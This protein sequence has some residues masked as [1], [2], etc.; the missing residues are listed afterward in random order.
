MLSLSLA[1]KTK[2]KIEYLW[3]MVDAPLS[4]HYLQFEFIL[5]SVVVLEVVELYLLLLSHRLV[6][7]RLGIFYDSELFIVR[8]I[9]QAPWRHLLHQQR[10]RRLV[11]DE[12][13]KIYCKKKKKI[14]TGD[15]VRG[16]HLFLLS[17][18][19]KRVRNQ[20]ILH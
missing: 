5:L 17:P 13:E 16:I 19:K 11:L 15:G 8:C 2:K 14:N 4:G 12:P 18:T 6:L 1:Q 20:T 7:P 9:F 10:F 3:L